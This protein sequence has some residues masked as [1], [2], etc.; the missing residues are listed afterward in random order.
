[1]QKNITWKIN[2]SKS[3]EDCNEISINNFVQK[4]TGQTY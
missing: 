2:D 4:R 1:M 3:K